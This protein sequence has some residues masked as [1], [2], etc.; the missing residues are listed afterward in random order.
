MKRKLTREFPKVVKS[1]LKKNCIVVDEDD[2]DV[3]DEDNDVNS[4]G[5]EAASLKVTGVSTV[6]SNSGKGKNF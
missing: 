5:G 3:D 1:R 2:D 4:A 6:H